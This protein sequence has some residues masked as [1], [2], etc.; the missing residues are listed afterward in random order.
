MKQILIVLLVLT[1]QVYGQQIIIKS[2]KQPDVDFTKYESYYWSEQVDSELD[3]NGYFLNDLVL[4]YD[5]R[6]AVQSELNGLGY[7]SESIGPDLIINFRVFASPATLKGSEGYGRN[8]WAQHEF[9][10]TA[11]KSITVEAG[12]IIFSIVD[13]R[14]GILVWQGYASG[15]TGASGFTTDENK[16]RSAVNLIFRD[17]G[18]RANE[19]SKR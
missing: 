8:Y 11:N 19:Y 4:K 14:E 2:E 12:T 1:S 7:V 10:P 16:L 6:D 13:R 15:L 18:L 3:E 5:L 9:N 17:Y